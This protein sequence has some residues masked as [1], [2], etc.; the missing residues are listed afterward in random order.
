MS[1]INKYRVYCSTEGKYET[2]W[3]QT[4]PITCP[5]NNTHTIQNDMTT[6]IDTIKAVDTKVFIASKDFGGSQGFYLMQG[7][8]CMVVPNSVS[9]QHFHDVKFP[10]NVCIYGLEFRTN[11]IHRGDSIDIIFSPNTIVGVIFQRIDTSSTTFMVSPTVLENIS[12][13]FNV[14]I[15]D[16]VN[17]CDCGSLVSNDLNSGTITVE[18]APNYI[19]DIGAYVSLS[20]YA[21]KNYQIT[22]P[23]KYKVG[24]GT[25]AGKTIP[26]NV[27]IR[28]VYHNQSDQQ[29]TF[30]FAY[31][32]T[33]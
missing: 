13:G 3:A 31:E 4:P 6:I 21:V 7:Q 18:I 17:T 2:V 26:P 19:F 12:M 14:S 5:N 16:G 11:E 33:Y 24:Y 8:T 27:V 10:Y 23:G 1:Y 32:I 30:A 29:K 22:E 15:S 9:H 25:L 28:L 20:I